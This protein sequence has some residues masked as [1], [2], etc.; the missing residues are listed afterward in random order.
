MTLALASCTTT[1]PVIIDTFIP[2]QASTE[3]PDKYDDCTEDPLGGTPVAET[4]RAAGNPG[5]QVVRPCVA[6]VIRTALGPIAIP[7][8]A[9]ASP[10]AKP[11]VVRSGR[12]P[13]FIPSARRFWAG[14]DVESALQPGGCCSNR[15][16]TSAGTSAGSSRT[17]ERRPSRVTI[18]WR[19]SAAT[20]SRS[21]SR[22]ATTLLIARSHGS[23]QIPV[24]LPDPEVSMMTARDLQPDGSVAVSGPTP[25]A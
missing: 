19:R 6:Q 7:A 24:A 12:K 13:R 4:A 8:V 3:A 15:T 10:G 17:R 23:G 21:F 20:K 11:A 9:V 2:P 5:D 22:H 16:A 14:E 1:P 18:P 25:R